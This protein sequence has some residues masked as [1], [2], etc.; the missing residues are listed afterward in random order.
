M[1]G[2]RKERR[3]THKTT[4]CVCVECVCNY[5]CVLNKAKRSESNTIKFCTDI[6]TQRAKQA[7]KRLN[8]SEKKKGKTKCVYIG[9]YECRYLWAWCLGIYFFS[10]FLVVDINW[11]YI[12]RS[13]RAPGGVETRSVSFF[14]RLSSSKSPL[15]CTGPLISLTALLSTCSHNH[16]RANVFVCVHVRVRVCIHVHE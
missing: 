11:I 12:I 14:L 7:N 16:P 13:Y 4:T 10:V 2:G 8:A 15:Q 3:N 5:L 1:E 9:V 6:Q